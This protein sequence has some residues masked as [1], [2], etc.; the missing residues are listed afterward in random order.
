ML[1]AD[2]EVKLQKFLDIWSKEN[3]VDIKLTVNLCTL[4][5]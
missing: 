3:V 2:I 1:L 5:K 4:T